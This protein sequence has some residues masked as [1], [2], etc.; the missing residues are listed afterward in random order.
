MEEK[1]Y[2][3]LCHS[4]PFGLKVNY[5]NDVYTLVGVNGYHEVL[6]E[7]SNGICQ[8]YTVGIEDIK[9]YLRP[10]SSRSKEEVEETVKLVSDLWDK[11]RTWKCANLVDFYI[12]RHLDYDYCLINE[13]YAIKA[14]EGMYDSILKK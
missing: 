12:K 6:L 10:M 3:Y 2:Y 5:N 14:P 1:L 11:F 13:G 9:P 4:I 8:N 7:D